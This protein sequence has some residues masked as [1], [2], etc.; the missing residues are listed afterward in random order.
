M[1]RFLLVFMICG[2]ASTSLW[3]V[4]TY[5]PST[6]D[7][8]GFHKV[9]GSGSL[10]LVTDDPVAY[11]SD[12]PM[13]GDVGYRGTLGPDPDWIGIGTSNL[14][15]SSYTEYGLIL[16]NDDDDTWTVALGMQIGGTAYFSPAVDL[17]PGTGTSLIWDISG[18]SG[19][20][21]VALIGFTVANPKGAADVYHVS[22]SPIPAPGA[23][24]LGGIGAG[25]VGWLRRRRSL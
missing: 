5:T 3:A 9:A 23:V 16:F 24:L 10:A 22:A 19:L 17:A 8:L 21:D 13:Q 4:P 11:A 12:Y 14:D 1:K 25:L 15:L 18:F 20:D 2:L 6:A 7:L